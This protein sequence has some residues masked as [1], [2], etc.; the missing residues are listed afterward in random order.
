MAKI[1]VYTQSDIILMDEP[2]GAVDEVTRR[3]LQ[4]EILGFMRNAWEDYSH[5][6]LMILKRRSSWGQGLFF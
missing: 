3:G 5:I 2:F 1:A 4:E 6:V